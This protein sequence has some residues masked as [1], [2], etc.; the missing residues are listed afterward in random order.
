MD[1]DV[2]GV[3]AGWYPDPLG[4]PQLRWWDSQAW[5]EHTSEARAPI[6]VQPAVRVVEPEV[7][8]VVEVAQAAQGEQ[9]LSRR[10][11]RERERQASGVDFSGTLTETETDGEFDE[12]SAQPLLEMTLR[13]LEPPLTESVDG[14]TPGP[15]RASAHANAVAVESVLSAMAEEVAPERSLKRMRTFTFSVWLIAFMPTLQLITMLLMIIVLG[16]GDNFALMVAVVTFPFVLV[17][18][19]ATYDRLELITW[20][21]RIPASPWWAVLGVPVYL[22]VRSIRTFKETG[23]GFSP[24]TVWF[25]SFA[26]IIAAILVFPG[27]VI[28]LFPGPFTQQIEESVSAAASALGDDLTV[29][30]PA[31]P[32]F[33]GESISCTVN[34]SRNALQSIEVS[35]QRENGWIA[36]RVDDWP[37]WV[38]TL[39]TSP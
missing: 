3:S 33:I 31:P 12:L 37:S 4:L 38:G 10:E 8:V 28:S 14:W 6:V 21:H 9:V 18:G 13:E 15:K 23:K 32:L 24:F 16:I 20:G 34:E 1:D 39:D 30:C 27:L 5:T 35:L 17:L 26:V 2:F 22:L 29:D 7:E 25:G 19:L 11:Q 36:W